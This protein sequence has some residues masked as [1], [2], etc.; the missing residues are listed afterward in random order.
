M[1]CLAKVPLP[2]FKQKNIHSKTFDSVFIGYAQ[3]NAMLHI[4]S[5]HCMTFL[6]MSFGMHNCL[7]KFFL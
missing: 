4:D 5:C 3:N 6:Y 2:V 1:E 7:S